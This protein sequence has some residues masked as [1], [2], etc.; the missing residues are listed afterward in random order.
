[1]YRGHVTNAIVLVCTRQLGG[2]R[3]DISSWTIPDGALDT[4]IGAEEAGSEEA[5]YEDVHSSGHHYSHPGG[6]GE[7]L[8]I[9]EVSP[10]PKKVLG[11]GSDK[12]S[13]PLPPPPRASGRLGR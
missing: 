4:A 10:V 9:N 5:L 11:Q 13:K 7:Q 1:M 3:S 8:A 6:G 12:D 2:E